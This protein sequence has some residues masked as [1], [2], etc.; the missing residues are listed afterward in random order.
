MQKLC[1]WVPYK[2]RKPSL[3]SE[4]EM[5]K[6]K[7]TIFAHSED[8]YGKVDIYGRKLQYNHDRYIGKW[9]SGEKFEFCG[10]IVIIIDRK[11]RLPTWNGYIYSDFYCDDGTVITTIDESKGRR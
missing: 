9:L 3:E 5:N 7:D 4:L 11:A 6:L 2:E 10:R 8:I 1:L